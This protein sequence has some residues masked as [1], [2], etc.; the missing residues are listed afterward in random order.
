MLPIARS[1]PF[2]P[3]QSS[4]LDPGLRPGLSHGGPLGHSTT[5]LRNLQSAICPDVARAHPGSLALNNLK[6]DVPSR[7]TQLPTPAWLAAD[8]PSGDVALSSRCRILRNLAGH[9]FP[10]AATQIELD[11]ILKEVL[12]AVSHARLD[13]NVYRAASPVER[14]HFVACRLVSHSFQIDKPGRA[15][16]LN[17]ANSL[18]L[19]VNEE[20]HMRIQGLTAGWSVDSAAILVDSALKRM[21]KHVEFAWSPQFGYLAASPFNAGEGRRLSSMFHLIG[22]AQSKRLPTV[23]RALSS[24]GLVARGL[25]GEAS[26]G[27]GAFIQVSATSGPIPEFIGACDY[28]LREER[29]AR[30]TLGRKVLEEKASQALEFLHSANS[31]ALADALR[32]LGWA[33]WAASIGWSGLRIAP[34]QVDTLITSLELRTHSKEEHAAQRRAELLKSALGAA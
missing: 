32:V 33:R 31:I 20:D 9:K 16:L 1:L 17:K 25:F 14:E 6:W 34:R 13:L 30:T 18:S 5:P 2:G 4:V 15:L 19:M 21:S 3:H 22:L 8:A 7:V 11:L 27:I 29:D 28:L 26:R 12:S 24:R 10:H 23:L